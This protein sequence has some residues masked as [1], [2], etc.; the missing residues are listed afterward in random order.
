MSLEQSHARFDSSTITMVAASVGFWLFINW[1]FQYVATAHQTSRISSALS[2]YDYQ[3]YLFPDYEV[4]HGGFT[5]SYLAREGDVEAV[6][7]G[8]GWG[9]SQVGMW[10]CCKIEWD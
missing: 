6:G 8:N 9:Y 1:P 10:I 7:P 2:D 3:P 5:F 4:I